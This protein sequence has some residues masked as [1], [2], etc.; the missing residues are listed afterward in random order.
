MVLRVHEPIAQEDIP[1]DRTTH[2]TMCPACVAR[3]AR[4][5]SLAELGG[6]RIT[7]VAEMRRVNGLWIQAW[8]GAA[9]LPTGRLLRAV[10]CVNE[11]EVLLELL[12]QAEGRR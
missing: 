12:A 11:D 2:E 9:M 5:L 3:D 8:S 1:D 7:F 10:E 6:L 4:L